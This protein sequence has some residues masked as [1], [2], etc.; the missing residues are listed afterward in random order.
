[1]NRLIDIA[2]HI[3]VN[4][5]VP[6]VSISQVT[7]SSETR[8]LPLELRV[9]APVSGDGLAVILLSHGHGPSLYLPSKDGYGPLV[10]FLAE[11]GFVVIQPTHL[12]S[13][14]AGLDADAPG[15]P[16]FWRSRIEDMTLIRA[17][18][19]RCTA[20]DADSTGQLAIDH[21]RDTALHGQD[22]GQVL[23]A[24][25]A[26]R[27]LLFKGLGRVAV[28]RGGFRFLHG[29][30]DHATCSAVRAFQIDQVAA[31]VDYADD[32]GNALPGRQSISGRQG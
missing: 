5:A 32:A 31:V 23:K 18:V 20:G 3:P 26:L 13:K 12:N 21:Y 30:L 10:N 7:L 27:D 24:R 14:I 2:R 1:M 28:E 6:A 9:T 29:C 17:V 16:L 19:R 15:G 25:V 4:N 11:H 8:G 22:F